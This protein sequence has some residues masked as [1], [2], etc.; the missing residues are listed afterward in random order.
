[1]EHN[2]PLLKKD[3]VIIGAGAA[4]LMCA[5]EA[6]KRNRS[7]LIIEHKNKIGNKIRVSGGGR[8]NF[9]NINLLPENY[10]SAN[11]HFCKSALARFTPQDFIAMVESHGIAYYEKEKGRL[12]CRGTWGISS[13]CSMR[14]A[15]ARVLKCA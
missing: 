10:L 8:C 5:I 6:G 3:V 13:G 9:T 12:F 14:N 15:A 2:N 4:G 7:V 11:L 1:M